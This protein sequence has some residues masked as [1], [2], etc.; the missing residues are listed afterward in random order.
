MMFI[1]GG[2]S[3]IMFVGTT[4]RNL[5]NQIFLFLNEKVATIYNDVEIFPR[6]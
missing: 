6:V 4:Y 5:R 3:V 1:G 2:R